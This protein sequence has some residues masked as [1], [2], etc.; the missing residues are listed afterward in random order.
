MVLIK[1]IE[2]WGSREWGMELIGGIST[3]SYN[4]LLKIN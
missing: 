2:I 4:N 1:N 3:H